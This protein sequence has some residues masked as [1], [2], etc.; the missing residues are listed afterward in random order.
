MLLPR[1]GAV[2]LLVTAASPAK[3]PTE[4][5]TVCDRYQ[6]SDII[7]T[8]SAETPWVTLFDTGKSPV[9]KR[10][11]K[12]K[13][14]RFLVREW[15]KGQRHDKVEVWMTPSDCPLTIEANEMYLI[16]AHFDKD[17]DRIESNGCMGTVPAAGAT[18]DL[19]Y[20][21][22]SLQGP[23]RATRI[24]G[25]A[26]HGDLSIQAKSGVNTRYA[27]ADGTGKFN[28]DGLAPGEWELSV[29]GGA[30]KTVHLGPDSCVMEEVK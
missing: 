27:L 29:V 18:A 26:G 8:G 13:R 17:N 1:F 2:L 16:Y 7:F 30:P 3:S 24:S 22:A 28:F 5:S 25:M 9:H 21:Q 4:S 20:L 14:I 15:Y 6:H 12:S 19:T 11:E 10:S 23:G